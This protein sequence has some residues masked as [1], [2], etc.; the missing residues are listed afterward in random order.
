M[1]KFSLYKQI[2]HETNQYN[3]VPSCE[4]QWFRHKKSPLARGG[5]EMFLVDLRLGR[6]GPVAVAS[7]AAGCGCVDE[8]QC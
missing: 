8:T 2:I 5:L 7:S 4:L 6:A 3:Q 1:I